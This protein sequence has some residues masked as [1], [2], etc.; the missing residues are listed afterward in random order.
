MRDHGS[1]APA[2]WT[3]STGKK[4]RKNK[5]AR[6]LMTY[7]MT[8]PSAHA[9]GL[10]YVPIPTILHETGLTEAEF[11]EA[12]RWLAAEGAAFYDTEREWAW[13]PRMAYWQL[14][15]AIKPTDKRMP[16]IRRHLERFKGHSFYVQFLLAYGV[17]Y[18][19]TAETA[20]VDRAPEG[21]SMTLH[22]DEKTHHAR[23]DQDQG[24]RKEQDGDAP[25]APAPPRDPGGTEVAS[26]IEPDGPGNLIHV[27]R[28]L[29][30]KHHPKLGFW[31]PGLWAESDAR[32]FFDRIKPEDLP[33]RVP[34]IRA[35][36]EAYVAQPSDDGWTVRGFIDRINELGQ[37]GGGRNGRARAS[38]RS[39][40]VGAVRA[41]DQKGHPVG[42]QKD[43]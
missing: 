35:R 26:R 43:F 19:L 6:I 12:S 25:R 27:L 23:Q 34:V 37:P 7:Y 38:P 9:L 20:A 14:G 40:A 29:V 42:E 18:C 10:F 17:P 32:K 8:G 11:T 1:I 41:E 3:G 4:L 33:G 15:E 28:V 39:V 16:W 24:Q 13:V 30:E 21:P 5:D 22:G 2:F 31:D 36:L